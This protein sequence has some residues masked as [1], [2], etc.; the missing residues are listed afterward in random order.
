MLLSTFRVIGGMHMKIKTRKGSANT[1]NIAIAAVFLIVILAGAYIYMQS[2]APGG[3]IT[4]TPTPTP[5]TTPTPTA[6]PTTGPEEPTIP[7]FEITLIG[8]DGQQ[9]VIGPSDIESL[10]VVEEVGGLMTSAGSIQGPYTYTG[11]PLSEVLDLVGGVTQDNSLRVTAVDGYAM[12]FTWEELSGNFVT[13]SSATGDEVEATKQ[14]TPVLAYLEDSEPL[15]QGHGPVRLVILGEEGLI[16]EGHYWIKQ[17]SKIEVIPAIKEYTL[18]LTGKVSE[19]MDRATFES[20]TKC[21][22]TTPNHRGVYED[23]DG[24]IWTGIPVWLLV[25]RIDDNVTHTAN[26]YNRELADANAY[27]VQII[28]GDGYTME[29][30]SSFV[31]LNQNI[32]LANELDGM[33]LP[34]KYWPL[35]LVGSDLPKGQMVRNVA[36]IKLVFN[37]NITVPVSMPDVPDFEL[38]LVGAT[39]EVMNKDLFFSGISCSDHFKEWTDESGNVW[40]GMPVWLLVGR[41]DDTNTHGADA[42]NRTLAEAGYQVSFIASDGFHKEVD[43]SLIAENDN[44]IVAYYCNSEALTEKGPLR[45]VGEGLT[46]GQMVGMLERIEIISTP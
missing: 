6:S 36:E 41:V 38:T 12:V 33:A 42:F 14:L 26:A 18:K 40:E 39:T 1:R 35:R 16:S 11:V 10:T 3:E 29:L 13:F 8:A 37:E 9:K 25:G 17:V 22:D 20:G 27:T 34:D 15:I 30:N 2:N 46:S 7:S 31:K 4:P 44:I 21:P 23:E 28:A 43:S 24:G 19:V 45:V 5:T 32:V